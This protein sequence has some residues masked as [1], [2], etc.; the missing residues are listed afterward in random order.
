MAASDPDRWSRVAVVVLDSVGIGA[1]PDAADYGDQGSHTLANTARAVGGLKLPNLGALGLGNLAGIEG[2]APAAAPRA[3]YGT[4]IERSAGKDTT[5]GH[6]ELMG[7]I[8]DQPFA[9]YPEGFPAEIVETFEREAGVRVIGNVV[10]SGTEIIDRLGAEHCASGAP[11]LYTSADS[12]FQL[13]AHEDVLDVEEL[14]RISQIAR[15]MPQLQDVGRVIAR[16]FTGT[17]GNFRRLSARRK[18]FSLEPS[19]PTLLDRLQEAGIATVG[20]GKIGNIFAG[21]GVARSLPTSGNPDGVARTVQALREIE[22]GL[23]F[24]NL[25]DF[26]QEYGHRNDAQGYAGALEQFDRLLP[27][28]LAAVEPDGL[29]VLTADH[30]ND[31]TT[32]STDHSREQVPLLVYDPRRPGV[33]LGERQSFTDLAQTLAEVFGVPGFDHG[34]SFLATLLAGVIVN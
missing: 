20:V 18:D 34:Q 2:V 24:T 17:P 15:A 25:I 10:A 7:V 5:T 9:T 11:I 16:P 31:P 6:W 1:A 23:V 22:R 19:G 27:E 32:P 13:A 28:L 14:Y 4:M 29:L 21:R 33:A 8:L 26:D 30:G 12:V 3:S